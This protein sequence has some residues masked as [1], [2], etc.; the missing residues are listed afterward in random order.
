MKNGGVHMQAH[1][2]TFESSQKPEED[3]KPFEAGVTDNC[4]QPDVSAQN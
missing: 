2:H 3:T 1:A 4:E